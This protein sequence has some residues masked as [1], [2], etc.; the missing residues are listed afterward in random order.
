LNI[1]SGA[2]GMGPPPFVV[3]RLYSG[4]SFASIA[5]RSI[6]SCSFIVG[7]DFTCSSAPAR[8]KLDIVFALCD[9]A[10]DDHRN[11]APVVQRS[12]VRLGSQDRRGRRHRLH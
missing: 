7:E 1:D 11:A 8:K 2:Y 6:S 4:T 10:A 9:S 3:S 12:H 5:R